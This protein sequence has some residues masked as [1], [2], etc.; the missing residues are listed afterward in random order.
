MTALVR[1]S[2]LFVPLTVG[3]SA[4]TPPGT[5]PA[6]EP[7]VIEIEER[8][9]RPD[10]DRAGPLG[11]PEGHLPPPGECRVWLPGRPAGQQAPPQGCD[12]AEAD[13]PPGARVIY[14]PRDDQRVVHARVIHPSRAGVVIRIDLYDA[15]K[16]TYLGTE[17]PKDGP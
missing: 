13:A 2:M 11:I 3:L 7:E 15:E 10:P 12:E 16:G 8:Q 5:P 17:L 9:A 1:L 14:R 6:P 4:C